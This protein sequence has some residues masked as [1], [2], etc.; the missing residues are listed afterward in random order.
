MKA[1]LYRRPLSAYV[2]GDIARH[3]AIAN[4]SGET[5]DAT[6]HEIKIEVK[7]VTYHQLQI[8][9]ETDH[10]TARVILDI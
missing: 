2:E 10:W 4:L 3:V 1:S 8:A 7:A 9:R 5:Y 6:R